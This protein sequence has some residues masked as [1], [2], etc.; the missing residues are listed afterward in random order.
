MSDPSGAA[1]A[2]ALKDLPRI[3]TGSE[4]LDDILGGGLDP[5]R[6]YLY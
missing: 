4:G 1:S 3:S 5:N 6:M 2:S